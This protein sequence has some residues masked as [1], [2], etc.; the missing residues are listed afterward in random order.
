M[1]DTTTVCVL[2]YDPETGNVLVIKDKEKHKK[3]F[4]TGGVES[5]EEPE[6]A[7]VREFKEEVDMEISRPT[8]KDIVYTLEMSSREN[9]G[10]RHT[11][12]MYKKEIKQQ[13]LRICQEIESASWVSRKE[14]EEMHDYGDLLKNHATGFLAFT[15]S[16]E[17]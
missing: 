11:F 8:P 2:A 14:L 15:R 3:G 4:V 7:A 1:N 17:D 5:G 10:S 9:K 6:D 12:I 16:L 13:Y